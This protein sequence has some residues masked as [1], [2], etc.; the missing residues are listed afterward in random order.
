M[1]ISL[2][3]QREVSG[4]VFKTSGNIGSLFDKKTEHLKG[5][6]YDFLFSKLKYDECNFSTAL[7]FKYVDSSTFYIEIHDGLE[8]IGPSIKVKTVVLMDIE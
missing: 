6:F 8:N 7:H 2:K 1:N 3:L 5:L 4:K